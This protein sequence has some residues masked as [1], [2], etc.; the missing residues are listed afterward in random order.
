MKRPFFLPILRPG[1]AP[2]DTA[3]ASGPDVAPTRRRVPPAV[4]RLLLPLLL[5]P[6]SE[7]WTADGPMPVATQDVTPQI[8]TVDALV[9]EVLRANPELGFYQAEIVA[10]TA[11]RRTAARWPN[12]EVSA[13]LGNKQVWERG[14][15]SLGDGLAW[16]VSVAQTFEFPG[17]IALRKAIAN[18]QVELAELGLAQFRRA[19]AA[20]TRSLALA[21]LAAREESDAVTEVT[22]RLRSLLE[23][24]V[25]RDPAGITPLL[26]QR[27]IE[28]NL[29][30]L[31]RRAADTARSAQSPLLELNQ[32][33][34]VAPETPLRLSGTLAAPTH[35]P[36]L[37]ALL[38]AAATNNFE[39]RMRTAELAAQGFQVQLARH[40][41]YPD[42][43]LSPFYAAA[44]ADDEERIVGVGI[45]LPLP[46]WTRNQGG[47]EAAGAREQQAR[48]SLRATIREVERRITD[49]ALALE[50]R[51][52]ALASWRPDAPAHFREAA[53]LADRHYR[54][55][56][57]PVTLYVEMQV[58][59]LDA[60]EA[61]LAT[62]REALEDRE[63]L[64]VLVGQ[65]LDTLTA[66][67][68]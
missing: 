67:P 43:T 13:E 49:R 4:L 17:R 42:V 12:P 27:I 28:A 56:A 54:L 40:E 3:D 15:P 60:L 48:A 44:E 50:S 14:G 36:P 59:Y 7:S 29:V 19:L 46:L 41:R 9:E 66:D 64:E 1:D 8:T 23:V 57:V 53:A 18:Q 62:R 11:G 51:L 26:D 32:L 5:L 39:V 16:S 38:A 47:I 61:L 6:G 25:Q 34:G 63:E 58:Q 10:A 52:R 24:L 2:A 33:R 45:S 35:T 65:S 31:E 30:T 21:A 55:G 68:R 37:A 20:R 22:Q